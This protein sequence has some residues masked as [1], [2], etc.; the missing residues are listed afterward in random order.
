[1]TR[2]TWCFLYV[3]LML[4]GENGK[5]ISIEVAVVILVVAVIVVIARKQK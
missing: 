3:T 4:P 5:V 1:M 2:A